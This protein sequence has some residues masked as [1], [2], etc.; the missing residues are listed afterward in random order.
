MSRA[1][2]GARSAARGAEDESGEDP[3]SDRGSG[4]MREYAL[5]PR[6]LHLGRLVRVF[7]VLGVAFVGVLASAPLEPYVAEWRTLQ[8]RYNTLARAAGAAPIPI[9]IQQMWRPALGVTDRCITCHLGMSAAGPVPGDPLFRAHPPM[10]H[11]PQQFGCTLCHGGQGRATTVAAAHG[12]VSFWDEPL[13]ERQHRLAGCGACHT[14]VPQVGRRDLE[15]GEALVESLDCLSCHK[16]DGRGRGTAPDLTAVGLRGFASDWHRRH[17]AARSRDTSGVWTASYG[18]IPPDDL[19][20]IDTFLRTRVALPRVVQAQALVLER[21]CLGCHRIGGRGGDEAPALDQAGLKPVGDLN[22]A[23]I[24]GPRTLAAYLRQHL[25]D[26]PRVVAGSQMPPSAS[27]VDEADLITTLVLFLRRRDLPAPFLPK[28]R[29]R[30]DL[31]GEAPPP[32]AGEQAFGAFCV[33]CHGPRGEGRSYGH[34]PVRFPAIGRPDFLDVA[35]D[36]FLRA[37]LKTGRPGRR[38]P[39]LA[40]GSSGLTPEE[41]EAVVRYL[42]RLAPAPPSWAEV[43]RAR[44]E[45]QAGAAAYARDCAPCHGERGEGTALGPPLAARDRRPDRGAIYRALVEGVPGTAMPRY[46]AYDAGALRALIEFVATLPRVETSRVKWRLGR[47]DLTEGAALYAEVCAGCHGSRGEGG[48]GPA[49][50]NPGFRAVATPEFVATTIV[51][52]RAGTPMP[53]FGRDNPSF[54]RLAPEEV[55]ALARYV[56][57]GLGGGSAAPGAAAAGAAAPR[58]PQRSRE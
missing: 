17:L 9:A 49:L 21:G 16:L 31:L 55:L 39:A 30:R 23:G 19:A 4:S 42:R 5:E 37:T 40:S 3:V 57:E 27:T 11:D 56:V 52:G 35:S 47:G 36:D 10:P 34:I 38:M 53:A 51:R 43:E 6:D 8:R 46:S 15:R 18:E 58:P 29:V 24:R 28:D 26:P 2:G 22:F 45:A 54:P 41:A 48:L 13:L 12:F 44:A 20:T 1:P 33:G 25:L 50:A 32:L 14:R 7:A